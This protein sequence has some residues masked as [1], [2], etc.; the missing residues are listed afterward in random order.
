MIA[1]KFLGI[2]GNVWATSS[3]D[4]FVKRLERDTVEDASFGHSFNCENMYRNHRFHLLARFENRRTFSATK[5][6][7]RF[8]LSDDGMFLERKSSEFC[9]N[10]S[11]VRLTFDVRLL[12]QRTLTA[13]FV[14]QLLAV[15]E[16]SSNQP[17]HPLL[18]LLSLECAFCLFFGGVYYIRRYAAT[19]KKIMREPH[20]ARNPA[21]MSYISVLSFVLSAFV[22]MFYVEVEC[23][24]NNYYLFW[25]ST[26]TKVLFWWKFQIVR[27][28]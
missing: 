6:V 13:F 20:F 27:Y 26:Y 17:F 8:N 21:M 25:N 7:L 11:G 1:K 28:P 5:N 3:C 14:L 4:L 9:R 19:T 12:Q 23:Q 10:V 16:A 2:P 22:S 18:V 24:K 15:D